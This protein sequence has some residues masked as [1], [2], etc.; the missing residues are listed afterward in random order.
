[1]RSIQ[2]TLR[3]CGRKAKKWLERGFE[4]HFLRILRMLK[5]RRKEQ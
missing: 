4:N 3:R 1:M 5:I 2:T